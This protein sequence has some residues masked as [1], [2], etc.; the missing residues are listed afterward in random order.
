MNYEINIRENGIS[1]L[2]KEQ[3]FDAQGNPVSTSNHRVA[4]GLG[5]AGNDPIAFQAEIKALLEPVY[6]Q[7]YGGLV[8]ENASVKADRDALVASL[9][10]AG[11]NL[12]SIT[13][14]R[15]AL[16]AERD[17]L[18]IEKASMQAEITSLRS[19]PLS[20]SLDNPPVNPAP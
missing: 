13:V 10:A 14:E 11:H 15:D 16:K 6:G 2:K 12:D 7:E 9:E 8:A 17:A 18:V 3:L 4:F 5:D 20:N 1:I 19:N